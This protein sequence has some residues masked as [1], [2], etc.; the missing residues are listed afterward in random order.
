MRDI[1]RTFRTIDAPIAEAP[2]DMTEIM[3]RPIDWTPGMI[4]M[5]QNFTGRTETDMFSKKKDKKSEVA[6]E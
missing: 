1:L 6:D 2:E 5:K 4:D 3:G